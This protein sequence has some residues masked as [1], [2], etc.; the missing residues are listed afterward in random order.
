MTALYRL[1]YRLIIPL[2][3]VAVLVY[4]P[5]FIPSTWKAYRGD[6]QVGQL[7][8]TSVEPGKRCRYGG[9]WRSDISPP[10]T[11]TDVRLDV[12]EEDCRHAVGDRIQSLYVGDTDVVY[13]KGDYAIFFAAGVPAA[14]LVYL[15]GWAVVVRRSRSRRASGI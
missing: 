9:D 8:V 6:G 10:Q 1:S 14:A 2:A 3:C 5:Q 7:Q 12:L 4:M 15:I 13:V 11:L